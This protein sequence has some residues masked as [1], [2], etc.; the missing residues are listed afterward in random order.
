MFTTKVQEKLWS[1]FYLFA[2]EL[3]SAK[4]YSV[5]ETAWLFYCIA[6][7]LTMGKLEQSF[8]ETMWSVIISIWLCNYIIEY[9]TMMWKEKLL[10][11]IVMK[12]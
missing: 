1:L 11:K 8:P 10:L 4:N 6:V 2:G 12:Y 5:N 7:S 3:I 9:L